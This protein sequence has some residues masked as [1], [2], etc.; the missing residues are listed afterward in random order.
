M[1]NMGLHC[2][3][4]IS[5]T[6][7]TVRYIDKMLG[8]TIA[9]SS[10]FKQFDF[11]K[12]SL[13]GICNWGVFGGLY[14]KDS[15]SIYFDGYFLDDYKLSTEKQLELIHKEFVKGGIE[16]IKSRNFFGNI[17]IDTPEKTYIITPQHTVFYLFLYFEN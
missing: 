4:G 3:H 2:Y 10:F 12:G 5:D 13:F 9:N 16:F 11:D 8:N 14:K 17:L 15:I 6:K 1:S 7:K